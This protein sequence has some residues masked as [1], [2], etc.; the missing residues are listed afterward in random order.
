ML[1]DTHKY[2]HIA[3][4]LESDGL[5]VFLKLKS[6][7]AAK[8]I[9]HDVLNAA[10]C[11]TMMSRELVPAGKKPEPHGRNRSHLSVP[12]ANPEKPPIVLPP[13]DTVR[14]T[15]RPLRKYRRSSPPEPVAKF[16][17]ATLMAT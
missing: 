2:G 7:V 6:I 8:A 5:L 12:A 3:V 9:M 14:V 1:S 16:V 4:A 11:G 17:W 13:H 15:F 10:D